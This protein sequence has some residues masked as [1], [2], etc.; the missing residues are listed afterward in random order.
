M[1]SIVFDAIFAFKILNHF[2]MAAR[3]FTQLWHLDL[4]NSPDRGSSILYLIDFWNWIPGIKISYILHFLLHFISF[5]FTDG[6]RGESMPTLKALVN[7][8]AEVTEGGDALLNCVVRNA[9]ECGEGG[10]G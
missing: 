5:F 9:G 7:S 2:H 3:A 6:V 4:D 8:P 10:K 1:F